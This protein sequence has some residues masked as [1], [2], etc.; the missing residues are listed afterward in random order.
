M[1]ITRIGAAVM[2]GS[3]FAVGLAMGP[4]WSQIRLFGVAPAAAEGSD[5]QQ[6]SRLLSLFSDVMGRVEAD[7]VE[8]VAGR[9]LVENAM[10]G[11]LTGLDPHS[12]Y[13][14]EQEWREMESETSGH[15]GGIGLELTDKGGMLQVIS[16]I[17]GTPAAEAGSGRAI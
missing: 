15:F 16:P 7:Y 12:S 10:N 4:G 6:N 1:K 11:M 8:P 17:D 9:T 14:N 5:S 13:M 3:S 2:M